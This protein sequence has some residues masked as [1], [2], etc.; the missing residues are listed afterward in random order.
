VTLAAAVGVVTV[1]GV[2]LTTVAGVV[3]GVAGVAEVLLVEAGATGE[4]APDCDEPVLACE[5]GAAAT[6]V[7]E[8]VSATVALSESEV[9]VPEVDGSV[10]SVDVAAVSLDVLLAE[11]TFESAE[12]VDVLPGLSA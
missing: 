6:G 3:A 11:E 9:V 1:C 7:D 4:A 8:A 10:C 2:P 5:V 12:D